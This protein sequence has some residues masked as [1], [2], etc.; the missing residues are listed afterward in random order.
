MSMV[1]HH[2]TRTIGGGRVKSL[3]RADDEDAED[4]A[5]AKGSAQDGFEDGMFTATVG[6]FSSRFLFEDVDV[7]ESSQSIVV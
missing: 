4:G 5:I 2:F 7:D 3:L 6:E 1:D